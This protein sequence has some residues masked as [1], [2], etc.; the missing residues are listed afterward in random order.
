M[1]TPGENQAKIWSARAC[2]PLASRAQSRGPRFHRARLDSPDFRRPGEPGRDKAVASHRTPKRGGSWNRETLRTINHCSGET[3]SGNSYDA[4][5]KF[6][7]DPPLGSFPAVRIRGFLL[8]GECPSAAATPALP[9]LR[10]CNALCSSTGRTNGRRRNRQQKGAGGIFRTK[11]P[12]L[13]ARANLFRAS[14]R[15]I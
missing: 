8:S 11:Y 10:P 5:T 2:A 12:G 6:R 13:M 1:L 14:R 3:T 15:W 4:G 9:G 7:L